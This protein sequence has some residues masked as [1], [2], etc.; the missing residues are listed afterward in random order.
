MTA[1][2]V[3]FGARPETAGSISQRTTRAFC[4]PDFALLWQCRT[5]GSSDRR[6]V[7]LFVQRL[8]RLIHAGRPLLRHPRY[9]YIT[10]EYIYG[11][12]ILWFCSFSFTPK[13]PVKIFDM[14]REIP[15]RMRQ[16][17]TRRS[18][19]QRPGP[20]PTKEL[21]NYDDDGNHD[22]GVST[23]LKLTSVKN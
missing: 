23:R 19:I 1:A 3:S 20:D 15:A 2:G 8:F 5:H 22:G 18:N 4:S 14:K 21:P 10:T 16:S 13:T 7:F 11:R 9:P 12:M 6:T 17:E